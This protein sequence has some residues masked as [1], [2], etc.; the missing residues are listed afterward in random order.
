LQFLLRRHEHVSV[1]RVVSNIGLRNIYEF[2]VTEGL[3]P[4]HPDTLRR[5]EREPAGAV[6]SAQAGVDPAAEIALS[7]F[8][9]AYGAEAGSWALKTLPSGGMFVAGEIAPRLVSRFS[10]G[11]FMQSFLAKGR[12]SA[13]LASIP[14]AV[15]LHPH[16]GLLG[17]GVQAALLCSA[18]RV[19]GRKGA[20]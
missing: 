3:A 19:N 13:V 20:A 16:V 7:L 17:A 12:L 6:L 5:C 18:G 4:A 2:V 10:A 11:S 14:V 1:E 8:V 15:V 9:G